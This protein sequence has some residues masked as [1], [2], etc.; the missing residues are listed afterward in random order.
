MP[1]P[2]SMWIRAGS[3]IVAEK[4]GHEVQQVDVHRE[5]T[6]IS[7]GHLEESPVTDPELR[8]GQ[9]VDERIARDG[10]RQAEEHLDKENPCQGARHHQAENP[11]RPA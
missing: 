2:N 3:T 6:E 7:P 9:M 1:Q 11:L 10:R 5:V 4:Q 8:D